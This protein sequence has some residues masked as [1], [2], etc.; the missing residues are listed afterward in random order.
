MRIY[1]IHQ[2]P[3]NGT[4]PHLV[5]THQGFSLLAALFPPLWLAWRRLWWEA[6]AT[7]VAYMALSIW[8]PADSALPLFFALGLFLGFE[9]NTLHEFALRRRGYHLEAVIIA[10][11]ALEAEARFRRLQAQ[12]SLALA[13]P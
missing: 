13:N 3:S 4:D 12:D 11:G 6:S 5:L 10:P 2:L 1:A 9:G 7:L 8:S